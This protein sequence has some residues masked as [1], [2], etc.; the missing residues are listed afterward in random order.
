LDTVSFIFFVVVG[1]FRRTLVGLELFFSAIFRN[2]R[3]L[4]IPP[5]IQVL[6]NTK[7]GDLPLIEQ[8]DTQHMLMFID[9]KVGRLWPMWRSG[10]S[11]I[12]CLGAK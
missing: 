4:L 7:C 11:V 5:L 10:C 2:A 9:A 8:F 12:F 1:I 6:T 3:H